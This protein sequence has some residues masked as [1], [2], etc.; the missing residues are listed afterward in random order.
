MSARKVVGI[1]IFI[2]GIYLLVNRSDIDEQM[3]DRA[4][5]RK[6]FSGYTAKS[7]RSNGIGGI[8]LMIIGAGLFLYT[9]KRRK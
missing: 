5:I 2:I 8:I 3:C 7:V 1:I 9:P 4:M 6:E